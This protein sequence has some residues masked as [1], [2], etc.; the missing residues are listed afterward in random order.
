MDCL[1]VQFF[2]I[3]KKNRD[4]KFNYIQ[5]TVSSRLLV[6]LTGKIFIVE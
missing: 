1:F 5:K 2:I 4:H 6:N 3:K